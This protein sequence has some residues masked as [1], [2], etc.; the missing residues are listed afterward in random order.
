MYDV[1]TAAQIIVFQFLYLLIQLQ[2]HTKT[3]IP[4]CIQD[5][6]EWSTNTD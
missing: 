5:R 1:R 6:Q 4:Y 3:N 2:V